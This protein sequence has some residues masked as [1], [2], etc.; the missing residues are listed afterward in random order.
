LVFA[1]RL[2]STHIFEEAS[3][4]RSD[5]VSHT[6]TKKERRRDTC[7][8]Q[9]DHPGTAALHV[10]NNRLVCK[11]KVPDVHSLKGCEIRPDIVDVSSLDRWS[12]VREQIILLARQSELR[13]VNQIPSKPD[14][15]RSGAGGDFPLRAV[16]M[17]EGFQLR[18]SKSLL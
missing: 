3:D 16:A 15:V 12:E 13:S 18:R 9:T 10:L 11:V 6:Q 4:A 1:R 17:V 2:K 5:S 8:S 7:E 14:C